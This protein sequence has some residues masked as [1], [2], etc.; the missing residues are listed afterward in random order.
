VDDLEQRVQNLQGSVCE[1]RG[2]LI[3]LGEYCSQLMG[4]IDADGA[5]LSAVLAASADNPTVQAYVQQAL[6]ARDAWNV[7]ANLNQHSFSAF[8]ERRDYMESLISNPS[9]A[10]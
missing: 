1:L 8:I 7:S 6:K 3:Q 2:A 10:L 9:E 5:V 4:M